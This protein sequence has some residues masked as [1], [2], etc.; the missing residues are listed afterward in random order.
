MESFDAIVVGG[1]MADEVGSSPGTDWFC[2]PAGYRCSDEYRRVKDATETVILN[3]LEAR[4]GKGFRDAI[5]FSSAA[6]PLSFSRYTNSP[7]GSYMG[8][9]IGAG[10]YGRFLPWRS[11]LSGLLFAGQWVFPGFGVAG[12]AASGYYASR[13]LLADE[14]S[15]LDARLRALKR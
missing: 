4:L 1:G 5:H 3:R 6:T 7:G 11:P 14:G 2:T 12:A 9:S 15:D 10:E 8:F 13:T